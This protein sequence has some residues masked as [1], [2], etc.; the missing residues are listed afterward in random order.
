MCTDLSNSETLKPT[1][2][3][4]FSGNF[5]KPFFNAFSKSAAYLLPKSSSPCA[6]QPIL[7]ENLKKIYHACVMDEEFQC[8][9]S[10]F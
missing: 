8:E 4:K 5:I 3:I 7:A 6:K 10:I 1:D 9:C 2:F